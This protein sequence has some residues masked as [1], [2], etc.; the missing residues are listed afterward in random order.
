MHIL[1]RIKLPSS[2]DVSSLYIQCNEGASINYTT[3]CQQIVLRQGGTISSNSYFNSFYE[4]F[5]AKYTNLDSISYLLK[6]EGDFH[7]F[8]YREVY[9]GNNRELISQEKFEKCQLSE[10]VKVLLPILPTETAGRIY[11][12]LTCLSEQGLFR[13]GFITTEQ[14]KNREVALGIITCT[15][16]KEAY[17]KPT[18]NTILQDELL[19]TKD[20]KL[21][22]VDNGRTLTADDFPEQVQLISNKNVG[23]SG[24]FT[25][26]L[27][28]ALSNTYSHF[29]VMDDD[30]ELD[31]ES[32]YR[33]FS[34]YEYAKFDFA[35]S[36]S[37]LDLYKKHVLYEAGGF[38][39][40]PSGHSMYNT[41]DNNGEFAAFSHA[42][43]KHKLDL[44]SNTSLNLLLLEEDIDYGAFW[45]FAFSKEFIEEIGLPMPFFI[46]IDDIEF[47]LR[48]K[49]RFGDKIVAFPSIAVWHEPF[50]AKFPIWDIYYLDRN[51][52]ITH[53][54]RGSLTYI[55]AIKHTTESLILGLSFFDYNSAEM[56]VKAFEDYLKGPD[57]LK[58]NDPEIL[59]SNILK[60]SKSYKNQN[61]QQNYSPPYK[62]EQ[63]FKP[64]S[65]KKLMSL[66]T[67]NGHL[68][69]NFLTSDD[70]AFI[71]RAP[72]YS[73]QLSK[74]FGKKRVL[75]FLEESAYLFQNEID[76]LAG[77]KL[78]T[79]WFKLAVQSSIKWSSVNAEWK[80]AS[81]E[82]TSINFWQQYLGMEK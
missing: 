30:I 64:G 61:I 31:S 16:K 4:K 6:L 45:F 49:E 37:M 21:F 56:L 18:V 41:S 23:G 8:A 68:L 78:L 43:A 42:P 77:I 62:V 22:V 12:E 26:G 19:Q 36:G 35:V 32:I 3:D 59:H 5:Y 67:L 25:R 20:F 17:I 53:G 14:T 57:F 11:F 46:K 9:L 50:Y 60:L 44:Q 72:G 7:V 76:K 34:L 24:G 69:P 66:L 33:L 27:I 81:K 54:I 65:L 80:K 74:A 79:K 70:E 51:Y 13:E 47:G 55:Q 48:I 82:L 75:L 2:A 71:W 52:L 10:P 39:F 73:G 15:F 40:R 28:E 38:A 1:G 63:N 58:N 29:L